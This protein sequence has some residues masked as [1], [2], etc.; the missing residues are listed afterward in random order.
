MILPAKHI[1]SERSLVGI[2]AV[3][4]NEIDN[5]PKTVSETWIHVRETISNLGFPITFDWFVLAISW[6]YAISALEL[7]EGLL[8]KKL[9]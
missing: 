8:R 3:I 1:S 7:Y 9:S 6:L 5:T 2:G 4:L